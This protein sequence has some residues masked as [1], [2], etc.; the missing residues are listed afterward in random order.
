MM[1]NSNNE[2]YRVMIDRSDFS[3]IDASFSKL[4]YLDITLKWN[5]PPIQK[6]RNQNIHYRCPKCYNFPLIQFL[7]N[8]DSIYYTCACYEKKFIS[9]KEL[10]IKENKY[11]TFLDDDESEREKKSDKNIGFKCTKHKSIKYNKFKYF[12]IICKE[13]LCEECCQNHLKN[14]HDLIVLNFQKF[15]MYEKIDEIT[16]KIYTEEK[17]KIESSDINISNFL[18][19]DEE[20]KI[21]AKF[22]I[23]S[24]GENVAN[25]TSITKLEK[26]HEDFIEIIKIIINDFINYPNYY[27][28]FNIENI[29]RILT[30]N[31][32]IKKEN[33][34]TK[35][36]DFE[37]KCKEAE[38]IFIYCGKDIKIKCSVSEKMKDAYDRYLS[39]INL[40]IERLN[41]TYDGVEIN[42]NLTIEEIVKKKDI[43]KE[44]NKYIIKIIVLLKELAKNKS[45]TIL[46]PECKDS[47]FIQFADYKI[48]FYGCKKQHKINNLL[49]KEFEKTQ[50]IVLPKI[51]CDKC[52]NFNEANDKCFTCDKNLCHSCKNIHEQRHLI[53]SHDKI[54][55]FCPKHNNPYLQYCNE[56]DKNLCK[57]C[58]IEHI[59]HKLI[60]FNEIIKEKDNLLKEMDDFYNNIDIFSSNIRKIKE[61]LNYIIDILYKF[62]IFSKNIISKLDSEY[63]NYYTFKNIN[64]IIRYKNSINEDIKKI[65]NE[66]NIFKKLNDIIDIYNKMNNIIDNNFICDIKID[67]KINLKKYDRHS[68]AK[69]DNK[70]Y[71]DKIN[72]KFIKEPQNLEYIFDIT[73]TNDF[74][75]VNDLFEVFISYKDNKEYIVSKNIRDYILWVDGR[76]KN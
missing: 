14:C 45:K 17:E 51:K 49:F 66:K 60:D 40:N 75:G 54:N 39:K 21:I 58:N 47:T 23:D 11:L 6:L 5:I 10:F 12:C 22:K 73:N 20:N 44:K 28:F 32:N 46:C 64:E 34:K 7:N 62:F 48:N 27:H 65:Y 33:S 26:I 42:E 55:Y 71:N 37:I 31:N 30:N 52:N 43:D 38:L 50:N 69:L 1:D 13:N 74:F 9:I 19:D 59:N 4:E 2:C 36:K 53:I 76:I 15:E 8:Q 56:C 61:S 24:I 41:F 29:Y 57:N 72:Y 68:I 63:F 25:K 70:N 16:K 18:K 35:I 3:D 67:D